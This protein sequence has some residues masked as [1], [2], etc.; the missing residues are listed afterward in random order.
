MGRSSGAPLSSRRL[1]DLQCSGSGAPIVTPYRSSTPRH[2]QKSTDHDARIPAR[3]GSF[4]APHRTLVRRGIKVGTGWKPVLATSHREWQ[5]STASG[6][7]H[8]DL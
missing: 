1:L 2:R 3:A 6:P 5:G 7:L 4:F 8:D